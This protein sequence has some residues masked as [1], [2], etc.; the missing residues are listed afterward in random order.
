MA[1]VDQRECFLKAEIMLYATNPD[2]LNSHPVH[3]RTRLGMFQLTLSQMLTHE[4]H[5]LKWLTFATQ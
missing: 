2:R 1:D 3:I 4:M 5:S